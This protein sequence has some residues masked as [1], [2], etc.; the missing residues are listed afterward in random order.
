MADQ[1]TVADVRLAVVALADDC[2][3]PTIIVE[4]WLG[5]WDAAPDVKAEIMAAYPD[6]TFV[7]AYDDRLPIWRHGT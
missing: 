3:E 7:E 1:I 4:P 5:A 2:R 6:A